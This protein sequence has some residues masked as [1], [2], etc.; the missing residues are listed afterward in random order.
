MKTIIDW[1]NQKILIAENAED[2]LELDKIK[3]KKNKKDLKN[4]LYKSFKKICQQNKF[5]DIM[6]S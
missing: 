1:R 5:R 4:R 2:Q 6:P 3:M